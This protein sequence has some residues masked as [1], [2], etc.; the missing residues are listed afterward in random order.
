MV[1][2]ITIWL[3]FYLSIGILLL[4]CLSYFF[5]QQS[6]HTIELIEQSLIE[7]GRSHQ[8]NILYVRRWAAGHGGVY[9]I[10]KPGVE[11]NPFLPNSDLQTTDGRT[12]LLR[13]PALINREISEYT[14]NSQD[15]SYRIPG[16]EPLNPNSTPDEWEI[17][18]FQQFSKGDNEV[19]SHET[20]DS[21]AYY[22][23]M[24][25]LYAEASCIGCHAQQGYKVGNLVG[26]ISMRFDITGLKNTIN[27]TYKEQ[28]WTF[29]FLSVVI[30]S[31]FFAVIRYFQNRILR[32]ENHIIELANMDGLTRLCCRRTLVEKIEQELERC[33][34][35]EHEMGFIML[36]L[37]HFKKVND[38]YGH[39]AG[40]D[41][42]VAIA[43]LLKENTR[44]TDC[45][46]RYGGEELAIVMPEASL[47]QAVQLA[48]KLCELIRKLEITIGRKAIS[49]TASFGVSV[50]DHSKIKQ[51]TANINALIKD[52]DEALYRA[53]ENGR[54]QVCIA[55]TEAVA[56]N[57]PLTA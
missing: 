6:N 10:K 42:L 15:F 36:D 5:W 20:I 14:K 43:D 27:Q 28:V 50:I 22:R 35:Y 19:F 8:E 51:G 41:V 33:K 48:Y 37:D 47:D 44:I 39:Q 23:Y 18:A 3:R 56:V 38:Q 40:D 13:N 26:G 11:P 53:K 2:K 24:T 31:A 4:V 9:V 7:R 16:I 54:D 29:I 21:N 25:P 30:L 34:R 46:A 17:N 55:T 1:N 45:C 12:L 32:A 49:V 57:H 52:A